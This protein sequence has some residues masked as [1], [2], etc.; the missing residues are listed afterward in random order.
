MHL[1]HLE[2]ETFYS[3]SCKWLD[4]WNQF[5][6]TIHGND[7]LRKTEK[8]A[9]LKSLLGGNA[10][11][12]ISGLTI[13]DQNY[14]SSIEIL[15]ERFGRTDIMISAHM[16]RLLAIEPVRNISYLKGLRKLYDE[17]EIQIRSLNSLNVTSGSYGNLLNII[18][19]QKIP[20]ELILEFNWY[21]KT[22]TEFQIKEFINFLKR[23]K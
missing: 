10:L 5:E 11:S 20:E 3:D 1:P 18:I 23:E 14:D 22:N 12:S 9:Y 8:F 6:T 13:I 21:Q 2:I 16:N 15:K 7:D 17:C 19:L 4:F